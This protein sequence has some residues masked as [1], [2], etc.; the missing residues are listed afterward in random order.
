[1][2]ACDVNNPLCGKQGAS[3]V[4]G[5]QKGAT[6][7]M[8]EELDRLLDHLSIITKQYYPSS[9]ATLPG[10]GAAGGLGFAFFNFFVRKIT[11]RN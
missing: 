6:Q 7:E 9:D 11:I 3:A 8:V 2:I 4:Y 5:P 1:M 10:S